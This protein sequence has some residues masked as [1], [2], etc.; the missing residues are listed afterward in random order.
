MNAQ[1]VRSA[2]SRTTVTLPVVAQ[3]T[4]KAQR[5]DEHSRWPARSDWLLNVQPWLGEGIEERSGQREGE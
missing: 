3:Q 4:T 5:Y 1:N 2:E